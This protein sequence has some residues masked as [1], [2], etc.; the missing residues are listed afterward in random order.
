[1][2]AQLLD[3]V[4]TYAREYL[5]GLSERRVG[6]TASASDLHRSLRGP[7]PE[8]PSDPRDVILELVG[9]AE[10]GLAAYA[11]GRYFG[12]VMGGA[13]PASRAA[14]WLASTWDQCPGLYAV[15][16]VASVTG[17]LSWLAS[18]SQVPTET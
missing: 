3:E 12:F 16:P 9:A 13:T 6:W 4:A 5:E 10:P 11:S 1:M 8:E 14:D 18:N 15:S 7:L 17:L 2:S